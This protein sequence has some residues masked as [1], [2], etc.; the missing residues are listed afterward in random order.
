[1]EASYDRTELSALDEATEQRLHELKRSPTDLAKLVM[2][3]AHRGASY[4]CDTAGLGGM[5]DGSSREETTDLNSDCSMGELNRTSRGDG[6]RALHGEDPTAVQARG[7]GV[8]R[9]PPSSHGI[10]AP[11]AQRGA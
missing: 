4:R 2:R 1:M 10:S 8:H 5:S 9:L 6:P 7:P 3:V 11:L